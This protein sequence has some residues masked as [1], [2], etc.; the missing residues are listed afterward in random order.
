MGI[1]EDDTNLRR[2]GTLLCQL[3]DLVDNLFRSG[4]QPGR[5][6]SAVGDGRGRNALAIAVHATHIGDFGEMSIGVELVWWM[7]G[8][9][10]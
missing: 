9:S 5:G 2:S 6:V 8:S 4:L 10:L 3:A 1:T 7:G